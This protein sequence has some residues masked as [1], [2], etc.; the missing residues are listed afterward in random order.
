MK[1][2]LLIIICLVLLTF[3]TSK[4]TMLYDLDWEDYTVG[5]HNFVDDQHDPRWWY[6]VESYGAY[7]YYEI[8][9][10]A[11]AGTKGMDFYKNPAA[12]PTHAM[13]IISNPSTGGA[14]QFAFGSEYW[15]ALS[16]YLPAEFASDGN[17]NI[18]WQLHGSPDRNL[19]PPEGYRNPNIALNIVDGNWQLRVK[20]DETENMG[21]PADYTNSAS[22]YLTLGAHSGDQGG[23]TDWVI[24]FKP[25][26]TV[27]N[28]MGG[29]TNVY[30]NGVQLD[31]NGGDAGNTYTGQNAYNDA[32]APYTA[33]GQYRP[34]SASDATTLSI[35]EIKI[36]DSS[37]S[38]S[39]VSPAPVPD[40]DTTDPS[41][42]DTA[43]DSGELTVTGT[44]T[45]NTTSC[46]YSIGSAVDG[47]DTVCTGTTAFTCTDTTGYS[48]GANTLYVGCTFD[49]ISWGNDSI[50]VNF[51]ETAPTVTAKVI[52]A[53]GTVFRV[54]FSEKVHKGA[55]WANN[56][57][58]LDVTGG[59]GSP[60]ADVSL[61]YT[62]IY[63][64]GT[65]TNI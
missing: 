51:D 49:D 29:F 19:E 40:I 38:L 41:N 61:T 3:G 31:L 56:E 46:Q 5:Q 26:Y 53:S 32:N 60:S 28:S 4:A 1:K 54:T 16:I 10:T 37:E 57:Y 15:W 47:D 43:T 13:I 7:A 50:V 6:K 42:I 8:Q 35:D 2:I 25:D 65:G 62:E 34:T 44:S 58:N 22:L 9:T 39:S 23:W 21:D 55:S 45:A 27:A 63:G 59:T 14:L 20:G 18:V 30:K 12:L 48:E 17:F 11:R 52:E 33:V 24:H 64:G 36:G